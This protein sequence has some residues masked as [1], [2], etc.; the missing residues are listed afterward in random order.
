MD[1]TVNKEMAVQIL[2]L[3][4]F[5]IRRHERLHAQIINNLRWYQ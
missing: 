5:K 4:A 2:P 3:K 1:I